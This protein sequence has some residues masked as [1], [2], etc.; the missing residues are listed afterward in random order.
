MTARRATKPA[1]AATAD[2]RLIAMRKAVQA[3]RRA[4]ALDDDTYRATLERLT[5]KTSST[6]CSRAELAAVLDFLNGKSNG[7]A[8]IEGGKAGPVAGRG[9]AS[10]ADH[11]SA[12]KARALW[13]SLWELGVVRDPAEHALEAFA[14]RQ[15]HCDRL[16]WAD[17]ALTYKLIEALKGMAERNHWSQDVSGITA[18]THG[19]AKHAIQILHL[20]LNLICAQLDKLKTAGL[21]VD[22][23]QA[24]AALVST[25]IAEL[26]ADA[27]RRIR[28]LGKMIRDN[29]LVERLN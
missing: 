27:D 18:K 22:G 15:L 28:Q 12:K 4:H 23:S 17:Q 19:S 9:A 10:A 6:A 13:L 25:D 3:A 29:D 8:V 16:Q 5:G 14:K 21:L 1:A 11:P 7:P 26:Q 20:K 2:H 24:G